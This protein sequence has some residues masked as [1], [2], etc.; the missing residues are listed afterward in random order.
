V[1][2]HTRKLATLAI[3]GLFYSLAKRLQNSAHVMTP[4]CIQ[5]SNKAAQKPFW[6][7]LEWIFLMVIDSS[8]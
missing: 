1:T 5:P 3:A 8:G 6:W 7:L 2:S 4:L